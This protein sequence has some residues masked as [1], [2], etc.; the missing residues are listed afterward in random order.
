MANTEISKQLA[1]EILAIRRTNI[2]ELTDAICDEYLD[3]EYKAICGRMIDKLSKKRPSPLMKGTIPVWAGG[4]VHAVGSINYLFDRS[5]EP[6]MSA[7]EIAGFFSV[8]SSTTGNKA[9][10][11]RK[12]LKLHMF[13]PDYLTKSNFEQNQKLLKDMQDFQ[14]LIA[15][16]AVEKSHQDS[17]E[18][19]CFQAGEINI[20]ADDFHILKRCDTQD[21][22]PKNE[23]ALRTLIDKYPDF[24]EPYITLYVKLQSY[25]REV[26]CAYFLDKAINRAMKRL[27]IT[28]GE[29]PKHLL[30]EWSANK[31]I[32]HLLL[33]KAVSEWR[34]DE[35]EKALHIFI[36]ILASNPKDEI[37]IRYCIYAIKSGMTFDEF[38][39]EFPASCDELTEK[40]EA[41]FNAGNPDYDRDILGWINQISCDF[42]TMILE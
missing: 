39:N 4:I 14:D 29:F 22:T 32:I 9:G 42:K 28:N 35:Y 25:D 41:W 6:Y 11:I 13:S 40:F 38:I 31:P 20:S 30:W 24:Y 33:T 37:S 21:L 26:E 7:S 10:Q 1:K 12:M 17:C 34:K 36:T 16:K 19:G 23:I 3:D 5:T 8:S 18:N 15:G 27:R 2:I